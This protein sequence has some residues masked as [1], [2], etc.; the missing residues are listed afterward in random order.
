MGLLHLVKDTQAFRSRTN[1]P[2]GGQRRF[3]Q[4]SYSGQLSARGGTLNLRDD[5]GQLIATRTYAGT[6]TAT[7]QALR[8]TEI[9]YHPADPTPAEAAAM[10]GVTAE[11]FEYIELLNLKMQALP[12]T[13]AYFSQGI[14]FTFPALT[15]TA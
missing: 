8:I 11:D 1:G 2:A 13:N 10:V 9:Q 6:P 4:G 14:G 3:I 12:V 15:L 5:K 7:Q